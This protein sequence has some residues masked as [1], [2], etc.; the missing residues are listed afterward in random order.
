MKYNDNDAAYRGIAAAVIIQAIKDLDAAYKKVKAWHNAEKK[1]ALGNF[2]ESMMCGKPPDYEAI[3]FT[4]AD[5]TA[6]DLFN[7]DTSNNEKHDLLFDIANIKGLPQKIKI[8]RDYINR[9]LKR[10]KNALNTEIEKVN[11]EKLRGKM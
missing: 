1:G 11:K 6:V 2:V 8:Q 5:A 7:E 9:N 3:S 4:L 10:L